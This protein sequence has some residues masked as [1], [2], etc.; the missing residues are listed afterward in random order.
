MVLIKKI[1]AFLFLILFSS[2]VAN[3]QVKVVVVS[4]ASDPVG[5]RLVYSLKEGIR[6]S[7][8]MEYVDR[9][10]DALIRVNVVTLDPDNTDAG[11][12]RTIYSVVW[13]T[14]TFHDKPVTMYLTQ[15]VGICGKN[16]VADSAETLVAD[17]DKQASFVRGVILT[18]LE[19]EKKKND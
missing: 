4:E 13:T 6:R 8:S 16:R 11:G 14:Q 10:Q 5:I 15:K 17:T 2:A 7:S 1:S 19:N 9:I 3:A 18:I 12:N